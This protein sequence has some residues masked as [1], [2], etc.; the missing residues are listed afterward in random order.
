MFISFYCDKHFTF[1]LFDWVS[2]VIFSYNPFWPLA[3]MIELT[4]KS[5]LIYDFSVFWKSVLKI[6]FWP[7]IVHLP[8]DTET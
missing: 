8:K 6:Y 3:H 4:I 7:V 2:F 5:E 1:S